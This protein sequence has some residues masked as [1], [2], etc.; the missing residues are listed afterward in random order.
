MV[1][2]CVRRMCDVELV[3][4]MLRAVLQSSKNGVVLSRVQAD[5]HALTGDFIPHKQLGYR[6][7][8]NFLRSIPDVVQLRHSH[9]GEVR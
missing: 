9:T 5:Y 8:E 3:K 2:I 1:V 7:L 4:K 6:N